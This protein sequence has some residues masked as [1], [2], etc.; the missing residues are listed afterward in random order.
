MSWLFASGGQTIGASA[1]ATVLP[2][3]SQ[4]WFPFGLTGLISMQSKGLSRESS[5]APQFESI[6]FS[7]FS[8]MFQLSHPHLTTGKTI[9]WTL[10]TFVIKVKSLLFNTPSRS[11]CHSFSSKEQAS[12]NL[13]AVVTISSDLGAQE[14]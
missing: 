14:N 5:P 10:W 7:V 8:F 4:S 3:N 6:S 1:S 13:M 9:A 11:V 2:M 12:F